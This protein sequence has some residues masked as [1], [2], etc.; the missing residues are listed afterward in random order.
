M[1]GRNDRIGFAGLHHLHGDTDRGRLLLAKRGGGRLMHFNDLGGVTYAK[2]QAAV[3]VYL[4][5]GSEE[6]FITDKGD[7]ATRFSCGKEGTLNQRSGALIAS[8][9]VN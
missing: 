9:R 8:H 6:M 5:L 3:G 1:S 7:L 2:W 4:H